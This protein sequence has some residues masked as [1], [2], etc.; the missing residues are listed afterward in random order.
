MKYNIAK[1]TPTSNKNINYIFENYE[2]KLKF[3][4]KDTYFIKLLYTLLD[5]ASDT[6]IEHTTTTDNIPVKNIDPSFISLEILKFINTNEFIHHN[7]HFK[8]KDATYNVNIY[9][10][11]EIQLNKYIYF[12]K[13]ILIMC[14]QHATTRYNVFTFKIILTDFKKEQS[15]IPVERD[16]IN[17]G[18]TSC[19]VIEGPD[20]HK[21]IIIFRKEEWFKVFIH[22]CFHLF[23]LDFAS[24]EKD[25]IKLFQPLFNIESNFLFYESLCEFWARTLNIAVISYSTKKN[26]MYE[27]FEELMKI[28][29]QIEKIYSLL[30]MKHIL[31]NMGFTYESLMDKKRER[32]YKENTNLFCYY[33]LTPILFFHYEQTMSW[34]IE[35]NQTLLQFT[36]DKKSILLFFYYIK[37]IYKHKP[38]LQ[39]IDSLDS[40]KLTN[41]YMSVFEILI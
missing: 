7:I 19:P 21:E 31:G 11:S 13:L 35:H 6:K 15:V 40:Y 12:I 8:I 36:K 9:T 4:I 1:L 39:M 26:I 16:T 14:S 22:E 34:F 30:Q 10:Q 2:S 17:S 32:P 27:E 37:S 5:R 23:C 29:I 20:D 3:E 33:V 41:N 24:S 28:N 25:Y 18:S 38:L